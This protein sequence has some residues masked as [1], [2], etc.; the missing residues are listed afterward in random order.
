VFSVLK[1]QHRVTYLITSSLEIHYILLQCKM[2]PK[3]SQ[4]Y[5]LKVIFE[6]DCRPILGT[7]SVKPTLPALRNRMRHVLQKQT[8]LH[9]SKL[10]TQRPVLYLK[11][12]MFRRLDSVSVFS[13]EIWTSSIDWAQL[14]E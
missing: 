8:G 6:A 12:T 7:C 11:H 14:S 13:P 2:E 3:P 4:G 9:V 5:L 10:D 1:H